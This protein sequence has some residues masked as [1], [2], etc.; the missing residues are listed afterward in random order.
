ML[1]ISGMKI[2]TAEDIRAI[3]RKTIENDGLTPLD[4]VSRYAEA[5]VQE[6][7]AR[8]RPSRRVVV[9]AG[10]HA[11]GSFALAVARLMCGMGFA[12]EVFLFNIGGNRLNAECRICRDQLMGI[13]GVALTEVTDTMELPALNSQTVVIDGLF[14]IDLQQSLAGGFVSLVQHINDSKAFVL[15]ID[16]PSGMF[17]DWNPNLVMRNVVHASLTMAVG[18]PHICFLLADGAEAVGEWKVV[19]VGYSIEAMRSTPTR[20]HLVDSYD[21]GRLIKSRPEFASKADFGDALLVAGSYGMMGAAV[22]A[23]SGALRAGAGKV[24]VLSPRCGYM[25]LQSSVPEAMFIPDKHDTVL[26]GIHPPRKF[27]AVGVGPGLGCN[28]ITVNALDDFLKHNE[29]PLVLDADALNCIARK[30]ELLKFIPGLSVLTP[31]AGEFDRLFGQHESAESRL[32]K[33]VQVADNCRVLVVLKGRYT[34]VVRPDGQVYFNL[35][36]TPAMATPGSG[37]VLTGILTAFLA[38]GYKPE[39]ATLIAAHVHGVA[40]ELAADKNGEYGV[41]AGDIASFT[42]QAIKEVMKKQSVR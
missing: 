4:M 37:D 27:S 20:Y 2:F 9:F 8:F 26:S 19:D 3:E 6:I 25:V 34:A 18:F 22:L 35:S 42:G 29:S 12:P 15:S 1:K 5:V 13:D 17:A 10:P 31:H 16:I 36:G 39:V 38:Q 41:T 30:R 24:S 28:E 7:A 40:G 33:A 11:N 23:A 21:I 14:G 32:L